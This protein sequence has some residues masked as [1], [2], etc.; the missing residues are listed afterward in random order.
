MSDEPL[1]IQDYGIIGDCRAAALIG[2][3][4]SLDWLCWPEFDSPAIFA[5]LLDSQKGGFWRIGPVSPCRTSRRY[6]GESNVLETSFSCAGG[7]AVLT[8]LMPVASEEDKRRMLIPDREILRQIRCIRGET[9]IQVD[10]QP[11]EN[12]GRQALRI[13]SKGSLGLQM[14][15]S[16]GVYWL[17]STCPLYVNE[18]GAHAEVHLRT[19]E[20]AQLSLS[21]A[22]ESP[23]IL[24]SLEDAAERRIRRAVEWWQRWAKRTQYAGPYREA[25]VR[26]ALVLK[27][28]T[29][30]PSGAIMA[31]AT[32]SLPERIGAGLNWDYRYCWLRDAS[33]TT[34]VL[35]GLGYWD[36]AEAFLFW[37]MTATRLTQPRLRILYTPHG[38]N[39]PVERELEHLSGYRG[40]RPVRTGNGAREQLQLDVY[41]E[42]IDA[43]AQFAFRGRPFD[44]AMQRALIAFG[45]YVVENWGRADEGIWEPRDG[46][47]HHTH[48]RVLCWTALDRLSTLARQGAL[49]GAPGEL[50]S[51]HRDLV[52]RDIQQN[53]WNERLQSYVEVY[54]GSDL[55]ASLLMLSWYGFESPDSPRM[56][57][58]YSAIDREL[59]AGPALLYRHKTNPPEG[60][61][62]ICSFWDAEYLALGGGSL[63]Q[64]R[65]AFERLLSY[66]SDIGLLAEELDPV[67]GDALGNFPQAFTHVGLIS[68]AI[69]LQERVEGK[70]QL[71]HR[72]ESAHREGGQESGTQR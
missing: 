44:R 27:L 45:K 11:R 36:E 67:S 51:R 34:R 21:H 52:R 46:R 29:Y 69:S 23:A 66:R 56:A 19:G 55:D 2:R 3:N 18:S 32:T 58:T 6:V 7:D 33:L 53:A 50:F 43:A 62:G 41:G 72:A 16:S 28:L 24:P 63:E 35:L 65:S 8:D 38:Q 61:F 15:D 42:V 47:A 71:S 37:M 25:V 30:A 26:S 70:P 20:Q 60:A 17:R 22:A 54:G 59:R 48:S 40:S 68:A 49:Q 64:A 10:F 5:G 1:R 12:Y 31:A 39:A 13:R 4:G 57:G 9:R 14:E